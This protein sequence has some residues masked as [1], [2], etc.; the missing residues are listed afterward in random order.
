[1]DTFL[2]W[3]HFVMFLHL[4]TWTTVSGQKYYINLYGPNSYEGTIELSDGLSWFIFHQRGW[5]D[6]NAEVTCRML[7]YSGAKATATFGSVLHTLSRPVWEF[8]F[9]CN[10]N[11][12]SLSEWFFSVGKVLL[13]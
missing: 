13:Y 12:T 11:E 3:S 5:N 4:I 1:M 2:R 7:G 8:Q 9:H 6:N 10:G